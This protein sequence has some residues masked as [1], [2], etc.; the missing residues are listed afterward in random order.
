MNH[1]RET[2]VFVLCREGS[3]FDMDELELELW[4]L[5]LEGNLKGKVGRQKLYKEISCV[6]YVIASVHSPHS[7]AA[8]KAFQMGANIFTGGRNSLK[9][10]ISSSSP[11]IIKDRLQ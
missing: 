2:K 7:M 10:S 5:H 1:I 4:Y 11:R 9:T 8:H 6:I 3:T